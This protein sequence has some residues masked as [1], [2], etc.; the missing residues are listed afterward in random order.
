VTVAHGEVG[1]DHDVQVDKEAGADPARPDFMN[2]AD[3]GDIARQRF[4][5]LQFFGSGAFFG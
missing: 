5:R 1:I 4:N 2:G 3:T